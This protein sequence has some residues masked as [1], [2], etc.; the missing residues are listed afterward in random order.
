MNLMPH[1]FRPP[2]KD[3]KKKWDVVE[4][5]VNEGF[6]YQHIY[7]EEIINTYVSYPKT[8]KQAKEFVIKYRDQKV[9]S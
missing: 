2:K 4:F 5:L 1:R 7:D 9:R 8:M 6:E 3:E